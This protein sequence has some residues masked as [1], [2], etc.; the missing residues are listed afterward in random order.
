[1]TR[2]EET[3]LP[4]VGLLHSFVTKPGRR[5]GVL[6][7]RSGYRELLVYDERDPDAC[8]LSLRLDSDDSHTLADLLGA[9]ELAAHV[10]RLQQS[11]EGLIIDW[12]PVRPGSA[13]A[14]QTIGQTG[15]RERTGVSV[16]AVVRGEQTIPAPGPDH[17]LEAG[18]TAVVV[19]T[20]EGIHR[21]VELLQG[22]QPP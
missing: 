11:V 7:H 8:R 18:D 21:A 13:C 5:I 12:L 20:A 15:L 2:I 16:V 17:R 19:G 9:P 3:R 1:M 10:A 22:M 6:T 14:G 4:G